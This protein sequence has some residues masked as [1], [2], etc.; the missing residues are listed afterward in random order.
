MERQT[1]GGGLERIKGREDKGTFFLVYQACNHVARTNRNFSSLLLLSPLLDR[2]NDLTGYS[3][4]EKINL[5]NHRKA[6]LVKGTCQLIEAVGDSQILLK[7]GI[8]LSS[9]T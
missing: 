3:A 8:S 5:E 4:L 1:K 9:N 6:F 7:L 2:T